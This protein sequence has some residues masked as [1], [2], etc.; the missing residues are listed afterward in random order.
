MGYFV[1]FG[2]FSF[3]AENEHSSLFY[4]SFSF[5]NVICV[6]P[7]SYVRNWTVTKFCDIG[8]GNFRFRPKMEFH[9]RWHFRLRSR[10]KNASSVGLYMKLFQITAYVNDF[11]T[12]NNL[13]SGQPWKIS[14]T[15]YF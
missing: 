15:L 4:F 5:Q 10:M 12:L 6:G 2:F 8:T 3:S 11:Q 1:I 14:F 7:K 13:G 9:F